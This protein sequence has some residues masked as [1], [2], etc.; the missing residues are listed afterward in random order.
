MLRMFGPRRKS[1]CK[2]TQEMLSLYIDDRL[3]A[4]ERDLVK[5]HTETCKDCRLELES[6]EATVQL[7]HRMPV[8]LAPRSFTLA[9]AQGRQARI[10]IV[11]PIADWMHGM[12]AVVIPNTKW[13]RMATAAAVILLV[14]MLAGDLTGAFYTE[15]NP[16]AP[17]IA[18]VTPEDE[19][20]A[21]EQVTPTVPTETPK[22]DVPVDPATLEAPPVTEPPEAPVTIGSIPQ[23][24]D[25]TGVI[26]P[27]GEEALHLDSPATEDLTKENAYPWLRPLEITFAVLALILVGMNLVARRRRWGLLY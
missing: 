1:E 15:S 17:E 14:V 12:A 9:Q 4:V 26:M 16:S 13:L 10:P 18:V 22:D 23:T 25:A 20:T 21:S 8:A 27:P 24:N 5:Y 11:T 3:T 6:L 2:L 19:A 7:L